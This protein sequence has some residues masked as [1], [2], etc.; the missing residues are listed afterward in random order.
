MV[1][2]MAITLLKV[3]L[4]DASRDFF[5]I[6][7]S[8]Y[9]ALPLIKSAKDKRNV[10]KDGIITSR[11]KKTL[12]EIKDENITKLQGVTIKYKKNKEYVDCIVVT[13]DGVFNIVLCNLRGAITVKKDDSW[14]NDKRKK[15]IEIM[16]PLNKVR[17]NRN[18]FNKLLE[19]DEIIDII[20]MTDQIVEVYEEEA[21]SVPIVRYDDLVDY[22]KG[23]KG[24]E[25]YD[26]EELYD[27]MYPL[28][29]KE[30]DLAKEMEL[31]ERYLENRWQYRSRVA[32]A[33]F[34]L[35]F[36]ILRILK[37]A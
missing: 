20:V 23:Y 25:K 32:T 28:I 22:I 37:I 29:F 33:S 19:E 17:R 24:E 14:F 7:L 9:L 12:S 34:F 4:K 8:I 15:S 5:I 1:Y 10:P 2:I 30:K 35:M 21:S 36:Y 18:V 26:P 13:E 11:I 27:K 3:G 31:L 6:T 16:S